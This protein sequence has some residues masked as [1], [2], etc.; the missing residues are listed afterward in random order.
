MKNITY[1]DLNMQSLEVNFWRKMTKSSHP[2]I[3][4]NNV[5]VSQANFQVLRNRSRQ[6][7]E[8]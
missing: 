7:I 8:F 2:L 3:C 1:P 5:P 6:E 4:F